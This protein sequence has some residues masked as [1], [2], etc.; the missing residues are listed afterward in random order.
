MGVAAF[1]AGSLMFMH[2]G[3]IA[4][5]EKIER[6]LVSTLPDHI[7]S[8]KRGNTDSELAF[9]LFLMEVQ[10]LSQPH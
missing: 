4:H 2:N 10:L 9:L 5:I 1:R 3:S 6:A 7:Y 8:L